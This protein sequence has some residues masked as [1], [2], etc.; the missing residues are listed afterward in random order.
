MGREKAAG[1][2]K[3]RTKDLRFLCF[4]E[5]SPDLDDYAPDLTECESSILD[6]S[7]GVCALLVLFIRYRLEHPLPDLSDRLVLMNLPSSI[8]SRDGT[9]HPHVGKMERGNYDSRR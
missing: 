1:R 9:Y 6:S 5:A 8:F 4:E 7:L 3:R 2:S